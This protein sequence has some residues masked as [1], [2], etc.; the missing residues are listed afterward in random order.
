MSECVGEGNCLWQVDFAEFSSFVLFCFFQQQE[1]WKKGH[2]AFT[3]GG[4][5]VFRV[6]LQYVRRQ[7]KI[8]SDL[9]Y[10]E[11]YPLHGYTIYHLHIKAKDNLWRSL[12]LNVAVMSISWHKEI[13]W[14]KG[15][16]CRLK[17]GK[18]IK[19]GEAVTD[20]GNYFTVIVSHEPRAWV[21]SKN[22]KPNPSAA[23][24]LILLSLLPLS[25]LWPYELMWW[26]KRMKKVGGKDGEW[27]ETD[28]YNILITLHSAVVGEER[29]PGH[30]VA[31]PA[32]SQTLQ[33]FVNL[34]FSYFPVCIKRWKIIRSFVLSDW[35]Y[36]Q[37]LV[38]LLHLRLPP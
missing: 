33:I 15:W 37:I 9:V 18:L 36:T 25:V 6:F 4:M 30:L 35:G 8:F 20:R 1:S 29:G 14:K 21:N 10:T 24:W 32:A 13:D 16:T 34:N 23:Q 27:R 28:G 22:K 38:Y 2:W 7:I 31:Q 11:K 26:E 5:Q 17:V 12:V 19:R 3:L